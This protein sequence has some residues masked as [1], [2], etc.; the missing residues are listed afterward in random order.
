ML[1][2]ATLGLGRTPGR[3]TSMAII[4]VTVVSELVIVSLV[5]K[6]V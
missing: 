3:S 2:T 1:Y 6:L 4:Q 5:V